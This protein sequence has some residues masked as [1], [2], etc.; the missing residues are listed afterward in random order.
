MTISMYQVSVPVFVRMLQNLSVIVEKGAAHAEAKKIEPAVLINSRLYPDMLPFVKQIQIATDMAKGCVAR[1]AGQEPVKFEDNETSFPE[2]LA[3][4]QKT[5]DYL[6]TFGKGQIDGSEEKS[7]TLQ[8]RTGPLTFAGMPYL[9][10]FAYPNF[11]FHVTTAHD[12]LRHCG[13]EVG[14]WDFLGKP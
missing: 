1:L 9:L 10:N 12:I 5:I 8:M 11:Y 14:K 4:I 2:L 7:I 6:G 13:V 3:R